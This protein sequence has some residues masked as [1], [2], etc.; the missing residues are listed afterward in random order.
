MLVIVCG[1][2]TSAARKYFYELQ[3]NY[4]EKGYYLENT[5]PSELVEALKDTGN[6][7]TLFN[8]KKGYVVDNLTKIISRKT[9]ATIGKQLKI[10]SESPD[11]LLLD[12]EMGKPAREITLKEATIKEFKLPQSIFKLLEEC[13][14]GNL[15]SFISLFHKLVE[16]LEADFVFIMLSRHIRQLV[17]D[18]QGVLPA[19]IPPWQRA[20]IHAQSSR[21]R[22]AELLGF[23]G[24]LARID[25][26]L[27]T[28]ND[29]LGTQKAIDILA[30]FYLR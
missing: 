14:P 21:W 3:V 22:P 13:Y 8:E 26:N 19:S 2:D 30:S 18:S 12:W 27:K 25:Q 11:L 5:T 29:A 4:K 17:L 28:G 24:G 1:E 15:A 7:Y 9:A 6:I 10:A 20:K 23:Y 16:T